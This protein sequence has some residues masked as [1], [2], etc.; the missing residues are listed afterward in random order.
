M[1][2]IYL[3]NDDLSPY[4]WKPCCWLRWV[5]S[6]CVLDLIWAVLIDEAGTINYRYLTRLN[7]FVTFCYP[8]PILLHPTPTDGPKTLYGHCNS[9]TLRK[10]IDLPAKVPGVRRKCFPTRSLMKHISP[11]PTCV[12]WISVKHRRRYCQSGQWIYQSVEELLNGG[13]G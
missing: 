7:S 4:C 1:C 12:K 11:Q 13:M 10:V 3:S 9:H 6:D 2:K 5:I 8:S